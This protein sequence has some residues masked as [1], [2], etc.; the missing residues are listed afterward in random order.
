MKTIATSRPAAD[1][2]RASIRTYLLSGLA[3][4]ALLIGGVGG[5]ATTTEISGAVV[6]PGALVV[7][8]SVKKV[9]HPTGGVV[10]LL[11]VRDGDHVD[12]GAILVRLDDTQMRA[13]LAIVT[14]ALDEI[15]RAHV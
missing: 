6:A 13:N 9:Q 7:E 8:S 15:G 2:F 12:A 5:W 3:L 11:N 10:G 1:P 4:T 14:S